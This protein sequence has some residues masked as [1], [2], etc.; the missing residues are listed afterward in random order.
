MTGLSKKEAETLAQC[1]QSAADVQFED[2]LTQSQAYAAKA[3][4]AADDDPIVDYLLTADLVQVFEQVGGIWETLNAEQQGLM[5]GAI[6]YLLLE[7]DDEPDFESMAGICD[8]ARVTNACLRFIGRPEW[9]V[10]VEDV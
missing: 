9:C 5:K 6:A 4:Q 3:E 8:D 10:E 7:D 2:L 1:R